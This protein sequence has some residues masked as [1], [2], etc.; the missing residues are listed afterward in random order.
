MT[1][2]Q[3]TVAIAKDSTRF[4]IYISNE[5]DMPNFGL[6]TMHEPHQVEKTSFDVSSVPYTSS[7]MAFEVAASALGTYQSASSRVIVSINNPCNEPF[8][9][10][11]Q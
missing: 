10:V 4:D 1:Y 2:V 7:E 9:S 11:A 6:V 3:D 8:L 5:Q